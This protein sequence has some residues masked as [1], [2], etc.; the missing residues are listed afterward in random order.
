MGATEAPCVPNT[1]EACDSC[2]TKADAAQQTLNVAWTS[3][4]QT[5]V[6]RI[7]QI[8]SE[9]E[10]YCGKCVEMPLNFLAEL[11]TLSGGESSTNNNNQNTNNNVNTNN[12]DANANSNDSQN[13]VQNNNENPNNNQN[14][15]QC[16][17]M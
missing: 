1:R 8:C 11:N 16:N 9:L 12:S 13:Q 6:S 14:D 4:G 10:S 2:Y 15:N 5:A 7:R 3:D 17:N